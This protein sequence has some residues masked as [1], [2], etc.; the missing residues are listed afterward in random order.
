MD[1]LRAIPPLIDF[2]VISLI[3]L[4]TLNTACF[5]PIDLNMSLGALVFSVGM[6]I[7]L[8]RRIR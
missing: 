5:S 7:Y 2:T 3:G 6:E 1:F 8:I 4:R